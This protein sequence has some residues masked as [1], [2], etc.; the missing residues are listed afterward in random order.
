MNDHTIYLRSARGVE[1]MRSPNGEL[2]RG[3]RML[4]MA[5]DGRSSVL[6]YRT[7]LGQLGDVVELIRLLDT[8]GYIADTGVN[9]LRTE[10]KLLNGAPSASRLSAGLFSAAPTTAAQTA[11]APAPMQFKRMPVLSAL[12]S[13]ASLLRRSKL[14][15]AK[16]MM[17]DFLNRNLPEVA[18]ETALS[19]DAI[20]SIGGL[21]SNLPDY[22]SLVAQVG[23]QGIS[24]ANSL[25]TLLNHPTSTFA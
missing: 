13:A 17:I 7:L 25:M 9:H 11:S 23:A 21:E 16:A 8:K 4:L 3:A 10:P 24:H 18:L 5:I 22:F 20:D 15:D 6:S 12:D 19:L 1:A 2:S 14:A